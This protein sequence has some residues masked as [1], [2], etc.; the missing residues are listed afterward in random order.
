MHTNTT[1]YSTALAAQTIHLTQRSLSHLLRYTYNAHIQWCLLATNWFDHH[2]M[3]LAHPTSVRFQNADRS[4][5]MARVFRTILKF[6]AGV[7]VL[8]WSYQT[9]KERKRKRAN[10]N[11]QKLLNCWSA[12]VSMNYN[13]PQPKQA[14]SISHSF[15]DGAIQT[16]RLSNI[17]CICSPLFASFFL[18]FHRFLR[19]S[20]WIAL[21][22]I[23][24]L[25]KVLQISIMIYF[26]KRKREGGKMFLISM[27]RIN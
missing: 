25:K 27:M 8:S 20:I 15:D 16:T 22:K 1:H 26:I 4:R 19:G 23:R 12:T 7:R 24:F 17:Q 6:A 3:Q 11:L 21:Q 14:A 13:F 10:M 5:R 9:R 18:V 2:L